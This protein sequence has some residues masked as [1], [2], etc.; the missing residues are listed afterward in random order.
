MRKFIAP[1][2]L[3]L[4]LIFYGIHVTTKM[5]KT[6]V[7]ETNTIELS[8]DSCGSFTKCL[9]ED[10]KNNT[11]NWKINCDNENVGNFSNDSNLIFVS[12]VRKSTSDGKH[13]DETVKVYTDTMR[14]EVF[15]GMYYNYGHGHGRFE[16]IHA[17]L[18]ELNLHENKLLYLTCK[19][20]FDKQYKRNLF[21]NDSTA[22]SEKLKADLKL[23]DKFYPTCKQ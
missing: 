22:R 3:V 9:V 19:P 15:D 8:L 21:V 11:S 18:T 7:D 17:G 2:A 16:T 10:L 20:L 1:I 5:N 13:L 12:I 6:Y 14:V 23:H 4:V